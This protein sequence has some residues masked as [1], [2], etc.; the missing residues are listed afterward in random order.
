VICRCGTVSV[1]PPC[2]I[3]DDPTLDYPYCCP[4]IVCPSDEKV[5]DIV[6]YDNEIPEIQ[7]IEKQ[8]IF[9]A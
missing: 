5:E 7:A 6:T 3:D 8:V 4:K 9:I 1:G 2:T